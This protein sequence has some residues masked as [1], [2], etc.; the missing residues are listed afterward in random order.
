[1][2]KESKNVEMKEVSQYGE[3]KEFTSNDK[4]YH[5]ITCRFTPDDVITAAVR[6]ISRGPSF[7]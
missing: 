1:M 6:E 3:K 4:E 2:R 5:S 7:T